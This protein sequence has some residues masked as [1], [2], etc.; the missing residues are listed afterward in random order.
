M[1]D[2]ARAR[3][4]FLEMLSVERAASTRTLAAYA[5]DLSDLFGWLT[6]RGREAMTAQ[7]GDL[8]AYLADLAARGMAA[9]TAARRLSAIRGFYRF[10]LEDRR[11]NSDPASS[12]R[13]PTRRRALPKLLSEDEVDALF[14][15]AGEVED[16]AGARLRCQLET[17]YAAGLRVS[18]LV[19]LP[20]GAAR[21]AK[22]GA[23]ML[24][25]KG[26]KERLAPLT[27]GACEAIAEYMQVYDAFL[28][29]E[30]AA[31]D[32]AAKFLFPARSASGHMTREAFARTLK[33]LAAAAGLSPA[34]VSPHV[35]R[36]AFAT[37]LLARGADL[38][39]IQKLLGHAD[40]STTQIYA[41][42]LDERLK[43][44]VNDA[45]PLAKG[46]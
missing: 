46:R 18:E 27:P 24:R 37:H 6:V 34:K 41:H 14:V 3:E 22:D 11:I 1:N 5:D 29:A 12:L 35:I 19:S 36:H 33:D 32:R 45:H 25:G 30:G 21:M 9:S 20:I 26:G 17:L 16:A 7:T 43:Q 2:A 44:V 40:L 8:E 42:V 39:A 4:A 23:I 13:G 15:A 28:P 31:R 10:C 38:R